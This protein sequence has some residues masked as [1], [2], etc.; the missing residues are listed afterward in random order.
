MAGTKKST[1]SR[2]RQKKNVYVTKSGNSIKINQGLGS[3][4]KSRKNQKAKNKAVYLSG[5]P[6]GR[7]KRFFIHFQPKRMYHYWFSK[8][9]LIMGLKIFGICIVAGFIFM[10]G[11]FAYFRKDLPNL[12]DIT[13]TNLGG[14]ITYYDRTGT[15]LL[16]SD[17]N[18]VKRIPV[19]SNQISAFLK[20]ATVAV[21]D[22]SF[23]HEGAF[24][25]KGIG[26]AAY[27]NITKSGG[28]LQGGSTITQQLVKLNENWT[29]DH[30]IARKI[31]EIILA[32]ELERQYTKDEI[33]TGYLNIAPYGG[34]EYGAQA[35][36]QDYFHVSAQNLTL[37]QAVTLATIPKS[38]DIYSPY[39]PNFD[40][41]AFNARKNYVLDQMANQHF[42]T[43]AQAASA[44]TDN[45]LAQ[46]QPLQNKY[47]GIK[48][49]YFVLAAKNQLQTQ[50]G[51]AT[52]NR[53]GWRV[54][55]TLDMKDQQLAEDAVA[56]NINNVKRYGG[57]EEAMVGEN[58]TTGQILML[59]GGTD[60]ND[61]DHGSINY[62]QTYLAP[63]SSFK[64]YDYVSM[65]D[66]TTN[67]GA[68][69]AIYDVQQPLPGYPCT[70][71]NSPKTDKGANCLWDYDFKYPGAESLRYALAGS[72][73]V[74][75]VKAMLTT[76]VDKTI[77]IANKLMG[78]PKAY[79]CFSDEERTKPT[80]CYGSSAIG[81]GAFLHLDQHVNGD[82]SLARLGAVIPNTY[83]LKISDSNNKTVY[84][85]T[86]PKPKQVVRPESAYIVNNMLSDPKASYLPGSCTATNCTP[87][88]S[89]GYKFQRYNGWDIAVKTG[90][91]NNSY[92]GLM[93][94]WNTQLAVVS[95]VGYHTDNK[96]M[97]SGGMEYMTEPLTRNWI[98]G[99]TDNLGMSPVNWIA[100]S[101]IKTLP[102]FIQS[103]HVGVGSQ[104]PGPSTDIFPS[105]YVSNGKAQSTNQTTD[106]VSGGIA[107]SCTPDLAKQTAATSNDSAFSADI[108]WPIGKSSS[109]GSANSTKTDDVH[110][111]GESTPNVK[112][113]SPTPTQDSNCTAGANCPLII[114]INAGAH[115]LSDPDRP[116]FPGTVN[117]LVNGSVV[118]SYTIDTA[119]DCGSTSTCNITLQWTPSASLAGQTVSVTTQVIDSVL[120]S[121]TSDAVSLKITQ[122]SIQSNNNNNNNNNNGNGPGN[123]P[124]R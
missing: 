104:E 39:S 18:A 88:K 72:R 32:V 45:V 101:G 53:G 57:D 19:Q 89:G 48:A 22:K 121:G 41:A 124:S 83:I 25:V 55:T 37:G 105:W 119:A 47:D 117:I 61:A 90:T 21:E 94:A 51:A 68:G 75:A 120:D 81:D 23:Y 52:V 6:S 11:M 70:N 69:S 13:G 123:K 112:I 29:N 49:P 85:W 116:Q 33:L 17:Y 4:W 109:S 44:K 82:A 98:Q 74:P 63:G 5:L 59:V 64:P 8:K 1:G 2:S 56:N 99:A 91:T 66:G 78:Y 7:I 9:G 113:N 96:A 87:L 84:K 93:T 26:R 110:I 77:D 115:P 35:A 60:F 3:K 100:P 97:N 38:P 73:N 16:F 65:I 28:G 108:F 14:S 20:N 106:K 30:T 71:K 67:T 31:K 10:I 80:Q 118:S 103:T 62:A 12:K 86:Q 36:S 43:K 122:A 54:T 34:I 15:V 111:C 50:Y 58:V 92:D 40:K 114:N 27:N 102:A 76:G 95:W 42:I 107:T 79:Q 46:I 24:D